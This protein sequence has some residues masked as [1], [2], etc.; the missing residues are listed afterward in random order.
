MHTFPAEPDI[1]EYVPRAHKMQKEDD[2]API[3]EEYVPAT[4]FKHVF[5]P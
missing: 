2:G 1:D 4:Q 3:D 5:E